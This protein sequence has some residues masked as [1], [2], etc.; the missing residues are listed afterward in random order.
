MLIYTFIISVVGDDRMYQRP[1]IKTHFPLPALAE[2]VLL[3]YDVGRMIC[4]HYRFDQPL[5]Q[6]LHALSSGKKAV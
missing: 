2:N 1:C 4:T 5:K 6:T 3:Q